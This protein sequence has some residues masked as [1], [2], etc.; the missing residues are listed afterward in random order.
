M[1]SPHQETY[2][3]SPYFPL[4]PY[5]NSFSS[6]LAYESELQDINDMEMFKLEMNTRRIMDELRRA[7]E[8]EARQLR[9]EVEDLTDQLKRTQNQLDFSSLSKWRSEKLDSA[10]LFKES[11]SK[12]PDLSFLDKIPPAKEVYDFSFLDNWK[13]KKPGSWGGVGAGAVGSVRF[14]AIPKVRKD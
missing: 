9:M 10:W 8:R 7:R 12:K 14:L 5:Y 11:E 2:A 13:P 6:L 1:L 3:Y 4:F